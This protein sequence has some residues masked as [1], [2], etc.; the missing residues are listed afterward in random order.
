MATFR[1]GKYDAVTGA[2]VQSYFSIAYSLM[3]SGANASSTK[4]TNSDSGNALRIEGKNMV[5][6]TVPNPGIVKGEVTS[7]LL[8][9]DGKETLST[10]GLSTTGDD[11]IATMFAG[12][13]GFLL[14]FMS[15][16]DLVIG[17][18]LGDTLTGGF[19]NDTI[20]AGDGNDQIQAFFMSPEEDGRKTIYGGDGSDQIMTPMAN[21]AIFGG[22]GDD[23][24]VS[25]DGSDRMVG[26]S[27][28]DTMTSQYGSLRGTGGAGNDQIVGGL[29]TNKLYGGSGSD[30]LAG[31][32]SRD[33]L[34][35]GAGTDSMTG[36]NGD[37]RLS[38]GGGVD[39]L[40]GGAG[41]DRLD[42][43]SGNDT[44]V[45]DG[46]ND[47]LYGGLGND[48]LAGGSEADLFVFNSQLGGANADIVDDMQVNI[49]KIV[50]DRS[51]FAAIGATG[52]MAQSKFKIGANATDANDRIIYNSGTGQ[53][54]YDRDG[55]GGA[56]KVLFATL[57]TGLA[58]DG[59]DFLIIA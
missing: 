52:L 29:G 15:G 8:K 41:D 23:S 36:S 19:G 51:I 57:D 35:G 46:G 39:Q 44:V 3:A 13:L 16:N 22:N 27:G 28:N 43:G 42:G 56:A 18:A 31:S 45:G 55:N 34:D 14:A 53:L 20:R 37:D 1:F 38:G 7:L 12:P 10:T 33:T 4:I 54:Y 9:H 24:M 6:G 5:F 40:Y 47:T 50:L 58:L 2:N 25:I 32:I 21:D 59:A 30:F 17:S 26:G 11:L 49:D 48:T